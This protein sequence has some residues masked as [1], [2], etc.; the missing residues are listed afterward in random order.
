M[1]ATFLLY[2]RTLKYLRFRQIFYRFWRLRPRLIAPLSEKL[3]LRTPQAYLCPPVKKPVSMIGPEKFIF[4]NREDELP[5]SNDWSALGDGLLWR[6]NLHYFD[7]LTAANSAER[8]IWHNAFINKWI[9]TQPFGSSVSWDSYPLSLRAVN[10][11]KFHHSRTNLS[12]EMQENLAQQI[13]WLSHQIEW[14][15]CGNHLFANAKALIF[16]GCFFDGEEPDRWLRQGINILDREIGEQIL[17]DGGHFELSPMYHALITEDILDLIAV[18][19]CYQM[20]SLLQRRRLLA[21]TAGAML[22][23]LQ[24]MCHPDGQ[25]SFFN[26]AALGIAPSLENLKA[27]SDALGLMQADTADTVLK[28]LPDSGYYRADIGRFSLLVDMAD[29]GAS[30][31][32]GHAHADTLSFELSVDGYRLIVNGGT[33]TYNPGQLRHQ[34]RGTAAHST[35]CIGAQDSSEVWG[36]FRV[37]RRA[38]IS[39][40]LVEHTPTSVCLSASHN[41]YR[42]LIGRPV[43]FR[44]WQCRSGEI[45]VYDRITPAHCDA[46]CRFILHPQVDVQQKTDDVVILNLPNGKSLQMNLPGARIVATTYAPEFGCRRN[47]SALIAPL[48]SGKSAARLTFKEQ[49]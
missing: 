14:H 7:D 30:Y 34:E 2:A 5:S 17:P 37:A 27:Y 10:W 11:I 24:I 9:A 36:N 13:H 38:F 29:I 16:G 48:S 20:P 39:D 26:D 32:P 45:L 22:D 35:V 1:I 28:R 46:I 43:H 44:Q 3:C 49:R 21:S 8:A 6:Y 25:I 18:T 23:W 31:I 12:P 40:I 4:L 15:L 19:D 41:G 33:S 42:R 47:T